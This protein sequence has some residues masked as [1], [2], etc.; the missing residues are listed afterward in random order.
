M[1]KKGDHLLLQGL[2]RVADQRL[3]FEA[4]VARL[5]QQL[6]WLIDLEYLLDPPQ[7]PGQPPPTSQS[8]AQAVDRSLRNLIEETELAG[9]E[10]DKSVALHLEKTFRSHWWG[11]FKCYDVEGL[12]RTNNELERYLRRIRMGQRRISGRKNVQDFIIR[13]GSYVAFVDYQES[14]EELCD[15]LKKVSQDDF[16]K[17]RQALD[18]TLL[19]E[20][21]RYRFRHKRAAFLQNLESRWEAAVDQSKL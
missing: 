2:I 10:E 6:Q 12:P 20:Q 19:R 15:R 8:V 9:I 1:P 5:R 11:L 4:Q 3:P 16:L 21:K 13:Y 7:Q 17:E 14:L 18:V